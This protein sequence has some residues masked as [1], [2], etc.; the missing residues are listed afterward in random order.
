MLV[1]TMF[2]P[3]LQNF[4]AF[5]KILSYSIERYSPIK[6]SEDQTAFGPALVVLLGVYAVAESA[7][8][9]CPAPVVTSRTNT[10]TGLVEE[11]TSLAW[12][13]R[14][15]LGEFEAQFQARIPLADSQIAQAIA[16]PS[17]ATGWDGD[18]LADIYELLAT[19]PEFADSTPDEATK[20]RK[21]KSLAALLAAK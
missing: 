9:L 13:D 8:T 4:P 7:K 16:N 1:K 6:I 15:L 21:G 19:L 3:K 14:P 2:S 11:S 5:C 10:E 18:L 20:D 17:L 12:P